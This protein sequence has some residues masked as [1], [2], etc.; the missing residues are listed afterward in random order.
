MRDAIQSVDPAK[1]DWKRRVVEFASSEVFDRL[2]KGGM[3]LVEEAAAYLDGA[4]RV[5]SRK[6][7]R[8]LALVYAAESME[9]TTRLMQAASWLV[10]QRAVRDKDMKVEE[11]GDEKYRLSRPGPPHP[12]DEAV[13]PRELCSLMNR[14]RNLYERVWRLDEAL[15]STEIRPND[16]P[17][18][19][20]LDRLK[21]AAES[22]AFDPLAAWRDS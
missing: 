22:G 14:S 4:G 21:S 17:V 6:L 18:M 19:R 3:T 15:Y 9:V 11:A 12:V 7:N 1:N 10:V 5:D 20:Q 16:N 13:L 2:F 8:E